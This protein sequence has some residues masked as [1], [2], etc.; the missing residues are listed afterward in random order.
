MAPQVPG[1]GRGIQ[2]EAVRL[3]WGQQGLRTN[4]RVPCCLVLSRPRCRLAGSGHLQ[5]AVADRS[6]P[7]PDADAAD[8]DA[9]QHHAGA[10][11][12][13]ARRAVRGERPR[14]RPAPWGGGGSC[15]F[16]NVGLS[17]RRLSE[18]G[19]APPVP[20]ATE[21]V[22]WLSR[23]RQAPPT[24]AGGARSREEAGS[25]ARLLACRFLSE[26]HLSLA[27]VL[28]VA[29]CAYTVGTGVR[30]PCPTRGRADAPLP[31]LRRPSTS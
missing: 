2:A 10:G 9:R 5:G 27:S 4:G 21:P 31:V 29:A 3:G 30:A 13:A 1:P 20:R 6:L 18:R 7:G 28:W 26:T 19:R 14:R 23:P 25:T 11:R 12:Q 8:P 16:R 24:P 22:A 15:G 17:Q